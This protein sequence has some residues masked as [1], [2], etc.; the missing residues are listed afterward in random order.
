MIM[1]RG[2]HYGYGGYTPIWVDN[3]SIVHNFMNYFSASNSDDLDYDIYTSIKTII[4]I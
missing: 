4:K 3:R 1:S 2:L